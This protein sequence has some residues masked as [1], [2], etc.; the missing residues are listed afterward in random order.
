MRASRPLLAAILP[1]VSIQ[2]Q[3][4]EAQVQMESQRVKKDDSMH[5]INSIVPTPLSL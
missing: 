4:G 5:Y 3:K 1:I 2:E